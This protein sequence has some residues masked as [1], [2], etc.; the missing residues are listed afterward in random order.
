MFWCMKTYEEF[1]YRRVW[2]DP[3]RLDCS[4]NKR[5]R[6]WGEEKDVTFREWVPWFYIIDCFT[7]S[8][9]YVQRHYITTCLDI[10]LTILVCWNTLSQ[11]VFISTYACT[12]QSFWLGYECIW[13]WVAQLYSCILN[14]KDTKISTRGYL[15]PRP[16]LQKRSV[17]WMGFTL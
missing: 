14:R 13:G 6:K 11:T 12:L 15:R 4:P 5:W 2:D 16:P 1:D 8:N 10:F 7:V 9:A 17:I 3:H